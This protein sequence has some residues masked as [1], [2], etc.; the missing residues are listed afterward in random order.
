MPP[1]QEGFWGGGTHGGGVQKQW[2]DGGGHG[3]GSRGGGGVG[4]GGRG[5]GRGGG[6]GGGGKLRS[7]PTLKARIRSLERVA[8]KKARDAAAAGTAA[9]PAL[10]SEPAAA[11][12]AAATG[13]ASAPTAAARGS[14]GSAGTTTPP[15]LAPTP[16]LASLRAQAADQE[17]RS[18]ERKYASRYRMIRFFER[19][20]VQRRLDRL[21]RR[22]AARAAA[23]A[24]TAA[25]A[26]PD[27]GGVG[28]GGDGSG[29]SAEEKAAV[30]RERSALMADLLY[31]RFFPKGEK[32][33]ALFPKG[34]HTPASAAYVAAA[35]AK[36]DAR[37]AKGATLDNEESDGGSDG[38]GSDDSDEEEGK[39]S[40]FQD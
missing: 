7:A 40:F 5:G 17:R 8:A 24:A 2:R 37:V 9:D 30:A 13:A 23:A 27:G 25:A 34:G 14:G 20:T 4:R 36:I 18:R 16:A 33:I 1:F 22:V 31:V 15:L 19:R 28:D 35:R 3:G 21:N 29:M 12:T 10:P 6:G 39:D 26:S 11:A 38:G 32:Y